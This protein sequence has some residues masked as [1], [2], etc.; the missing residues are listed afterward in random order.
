M[1]RITIVGAGFGALST[2]RELRRHDKHAEITLVAP[3]AHLIYL[4][5]LIWIPSRLRRAHDLRIDLKGFFETHGVRHIAARVAGLENDGRRVL[6]DAGESV[7]ND[8]LV[9]ASG[10]RFLKKLPGIEHAITLCEGIDAAQS[11]RERLSRMDGGTIALGFG[12]NPKEPQAVRGGPMFELMFGLDTLLRRQKRRERFKLVFFNGSERPGARL[13]ERAVDGLL[14]EMRRRD[15]EARLGSKPVRFEA[16]RVV[17]EDGEF[18]AD[19]ILFMPG[20]TGPDWAAEAGLPLSSGGLIQA[21]EHTRVTGIER[22][23]VVGDSGSFPGPD[24]MPK[25]A[26]MADLQAVAAARNLLAELDGRAPQETFK[27]ELVCIIDTLEK[28]I[29]VYRSPK[30]TVILPSCRVFHWLKRAFEHHYLA[31]YRKPKPPR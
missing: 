6:T 17:T 19:L 18:A 3:H 24:W 15:I 25:Q 13:G 23:Y 10:G 9:I 27:T 26:H 4:P 29:L 1:K 16:D 21:D 28:G 31:L 5:S 22:V 7:D 14:R 11:I 8:G 30:R 2:V 20:M 12:A